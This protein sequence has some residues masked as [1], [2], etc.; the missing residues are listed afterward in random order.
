[1]FDKAVALIWLTLSPIDCDSRYQKGSP[2]LVLP[3]KHRK[4]MQL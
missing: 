3:S 4:T 1:M 2:N